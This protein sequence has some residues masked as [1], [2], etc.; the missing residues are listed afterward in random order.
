V[1]HNKRGDDGLPENEVE[2]VIE[3]A[4]VEPARFTEFVH[5]NYPGFMADDIDAA[6]AA[7]EYLSDADTLQAAWE[8]PFILPRVRW[9]VCVCGGACAG[10]VVR[11]RC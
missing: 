9:C 5:E 7:L 3:Q 11:V 4:G 2:Q 8:V 6:S 1:L 10:A